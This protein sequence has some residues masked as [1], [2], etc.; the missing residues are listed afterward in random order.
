MP[1]ILTHAALPLIAGWAAGRERLPPR[2]VALAMVAAVLP[3][4]DVLSF[5]AGIPYDA[6]LGHRGISHSLA[7][8]LFL[9]LLAAL[10]APVLRSSRLKAFIFVALAAASHGLTD[11]LTDGGRGVALW[12]PLSDDRLFAAAR[13]LEVASIGLRGFEKGTIWSAL[14]SELVWLILPAIL[15]AVLYRHRARPHIDLE[16]GQT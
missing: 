11:M 15:L 10:A 7:F 6:P 4:A 9:G 12:W 16:Q 8:A 13:P 3:D 5:S 2:I 1:T 14:G